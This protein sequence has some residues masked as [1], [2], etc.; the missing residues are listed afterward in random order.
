MFKNKTFILFA[1]MPRTG[2]TL[3]ASI[4]SQ[5]PH[6][7]VS[8]NSPLVELMWSAYKSVDSEGVKTDLNAQ[9][10][11]EEMRADLVAST[12]KSYYKNATDEK[13]IIEKSRGWLLAAN[14]KLAIKYFGKDVKIICFRR[15]VEQILSSFYNLMHSTCSDEEF[16]ARILKTKIPIH[17]NIKNCKLSKFINSPNVL[18]L[19]YDDIINNTYDVLR[20]VYKFCD[21]P[22]HPDFIDPVSAHDLSNITRPFEEDDFSYDIN[23]L[24]EV[25]P[26]I[27]R[28]IHKVELPEQFLKVGQELTKQLYRYG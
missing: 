25:R 23:K 4:L 18:H 19:E 1:G 11:L 27:S 22:K 17:D 12:I 28:R 13:F 8:G 21:L 14:R 9:K 6:V 3:L 20:K 16:Y 24:H 5:N 7:H 26:T 2:S 10:R 15:P